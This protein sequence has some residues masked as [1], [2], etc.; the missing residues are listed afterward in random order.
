[1]VAP[2][3]REVAPHHKSGIAL[4]TPPVR[5]VSTS[6][7]TT[8]LALAAFQPESV[9][10]LS[11]HCHQC[12]MDKILQ[13]T[14]LI[15]CPLDF[16]LTPGCSFSPT[17]SLASWPATP[18]TSGTPS[19]FPM[20]PVGDQPPP[21]FGFGGP[22]PRTTE[23]LLEERRARRAAILA[24]YATLPSQPEGMPTTPTSPSSHSA[25]CKCTSLL[26]LTDIYANVCASPRPS[27]D[28]PS[29]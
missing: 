26:C 25:A 13:R 11:E 18:L 3:R 9:V 7:T 15:S 5:V 4:A 22:D 19:L 8:A 10:C 16:L 14:C 1:M 28:E 24:K 29:S 2:G 20:T 6:V 27:R 21:E 23:Q 12:C 17:S